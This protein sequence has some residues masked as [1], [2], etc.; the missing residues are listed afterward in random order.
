[1]SLPL[2]EKRKKPEYYKLL[3]QHGWST[4]KRLMFMVGLMRQSKKKEVK[5]DADREDPES[6]E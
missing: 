3:T 2:F 1:M 4:H 5:K 6:G